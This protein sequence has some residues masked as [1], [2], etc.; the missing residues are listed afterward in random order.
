VAAHRLIIALCY[1]VGELICIDHGGGFCSR[2]RCA[3]RD[4]VIPLV[5]Q[6]KVARRRAAI[7]V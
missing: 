5:H 7:V 3:A 6:P 1:Y 4:N 2:R